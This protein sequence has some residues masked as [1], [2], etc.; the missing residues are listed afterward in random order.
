MAEDGERPEDGFD[1]ALVELT[2]RSRRQGAAEQRRRHHWLVQQAGEEGT[3]LGTLLDLGEAGRRVS[4]GLVSGRRLQGTVV[5]I[6]SDFV[7][8]LSARLRFVVPLAALAMV[9]DEPGARGSLGDRALPDD[10][11]L[12]DALVD[13]A[14]PGSTVQV[15][16]GGDHHVVG[17][18]TSV[19]RDLVV[20]RNSDGTHS[21]LAVPALIS[22]ALET[23]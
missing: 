22:L 12:A 15:Q 5:A 19:G 8:L 13:L 2:D 18:V 7:V 17:T 3:F 16:A 21:Y 20:V 23:P 9:H 1:A 10:R 14:P 6:G 4:L 11:C